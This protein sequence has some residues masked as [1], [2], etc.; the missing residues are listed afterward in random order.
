MVTIDDTPSLIQVM[1]WHRT[2]DK[3][4]I[5]GTNNSIHHMR[6]NKQDISL[7]WRHQVEIFSAFLAICGEN[8]PVTDEFASL[9]PVTGSFDV[10]FDLCLN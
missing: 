4:N 7:L 10:F 9:S 5:T 8:S 1:A 2:G 6:W 3:K